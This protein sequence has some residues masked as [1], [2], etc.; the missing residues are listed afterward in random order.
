MI[1]TKHLIRNAILSTSL[2]FSL[3]VFA[4]NAVA[5][6]NADADIKAAKDQYSASK[7][8]ADADYKDQ[9]AKCAAMTGADKSSCTKEAKA[10]RSKATKEARATR[11]A[12]Y[13]KYKMS[14]PSN[15]VN[16]PGGR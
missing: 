1:T 11:N 3:G 7:S 6:G 16:A 15:D 5:Q 12:V 2:V 8:K 10:A 9:A 4:G 14:P 13:A